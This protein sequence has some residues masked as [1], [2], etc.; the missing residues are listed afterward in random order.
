MKN[1]VLALISIV[2]VNAFAT[3]SPHSYAISNNGNC[4]LM[5][6][7]Q[8]S[9]LVSDEWCYPVNGYPKGSYVEYEWSNK[10]NCK[11]MINDEF[12]ESFASS[13]RCASNPQY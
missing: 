11:I 6:N 5:I 13:Y 9:Q 4:K 3:Q 10:G 7:H 12:T 8:F 1:L 2:A